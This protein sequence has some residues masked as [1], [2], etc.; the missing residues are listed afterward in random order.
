MLENYEPVVPE[1]LGVN[2]KT[3][4]EAGRMSDSVG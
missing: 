1:Y 4:P 3:N 2:N